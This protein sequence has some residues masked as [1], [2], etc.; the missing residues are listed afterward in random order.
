MGI[1]ENGNVGLTALWNAGALVS[2]EGPENVTTPC[3]MGRDPT[4][5][6]IT[7]PPCQSTGTVLFRK[8]KLER[9][10]ILGRN[11]A[12][13]K[14]APP[15]VVLVVKQEEGLAQQNTHTVQLVTVRPYRRPS[16]MNLIEAA[17]KRYALVCRAPLHVIIVFDCM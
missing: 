15:H 2:K 7:R 10:T 13:G 1:G 17:M 4:V 16:A 6:F 8:K 12:P 9:A 5:R 3:P 11:G 14:D